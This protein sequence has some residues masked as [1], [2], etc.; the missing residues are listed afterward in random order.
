ML[1]K[2]TFIAVLA[3]TTFLTGEVAYAADQQTG[4]PP[5]SAQ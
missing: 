3:A 5:P 1:S 2:K 4:T